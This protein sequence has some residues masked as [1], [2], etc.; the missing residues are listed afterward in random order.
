MEP[1]KLLKKEK[2]HLR[3]LKLMRGAIYT[4]IAPLAVGVHPSAEPIPPGEQYGLAYCPIRR[5]QT[6]GGLYGCA[7]FRVEGIMPQSA[8]GRHVVVHINVGGEGAVYTGTEPTQAISLVSS[9]IDRVQSGVGKSVIEVSQSAEAG[10]PLSYY[11]DAGYNGYFNYTFGR[12][13]FW[14]ADLCAVDDNLLAYYYDYLCVASLSSA[15][16]DKGG[17]TELERLLDESYAALRNS[18]DQARAVLKPLLEGQPEEGLAFTAVGHSHL[19]LAWLW[20][21]RETKRKAQRTFANQLNNAARYPDYVYG[22]SQPW[23]FA[24]IKSQC[25]EQYAA[26]QQMARRGQLEPQGGMWVEA[27]TNVSSGEALIRQIYYGKT[28][29]REEFGQEMKICWLPDVFGYNGNLPQILS[30][31]GLPYFMT[32]KLSWNEHNRFPYRSFLWR[33]IDGS[34]VLVHMP[35]DDSY[36]TAGSPACARHAAD[37]YTE[38][39][40]APEALLVYGIGDGGGGPGEAHIELLKRQKS[41]SGSPK[42]TLGSAVDFFGRLD[43]YRRGLPVY[44]GE[45][46]LEKHQGTYTTQAANKQCNRRCEYALQDLEALCTLA[47]QRGRA[48]PQEELDAWWK[49]VL[50]FQFHDIIPGSS[51]TRVYQESRARYAVILREIEAERAAVLAYLAEGPEGVFNPTGFPREEYIRKADGWYCAAPAP[52]GFAEL[53]KM[54]P[55]AALLCGGDTME[56]DCLRLRF[57]S[58]GSIVSAVSKEDGFEYAEGR[59][60]ALRLYRDKWLFYNAWDIDWKYYQ[61]PSRLLTPCRQETFI[62]GP[63]VVRRQYY[64][65]GRTTI[66]QDVMLYVGRPVMY[67]QTACDYHETLTMLRADFAVGIHAPAVRC[68]IQLGSIERST[69]DS[70]DLEKAQFE[71]CA[72]KYVDV[73]DGGHGVSLMNDCKYGHRVKG[74]RLSLNLLRSPIYPDKTA[75]R[76]HHEFCYAL[77]L[78]PGACGTET[79]A[80]SYALNKPVIP[81]KVSIGSLAQ[82]DTPAVVV[83]TIKCAYAG[84]GV[85]LRLYES[86]GRATVCCLQTIFDGPV[87]ETDLMENEL[88]SVDPENLTFAPFETKT[89]KVKM[90]TG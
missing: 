48:Y 33:G 74:N 77:F 81:A 36:N 41:L 35:P 43:K 90:Q 61:K 52:Y 88:Q 46:Y 20:P 89:V 9:Y 34:E 2:K 5:G 17:R 21:V 72:H 69:G 37:N 53:T 67:F 78:H 8:A 39:A 85:I 42:V 63:R 27:D 59:L 58:D 40:L 73:S 4:P 49:E 71:I 83:E 51:I 56:N 13:I 70:S 82:T 11:I 38:R 80:Y 24:Y 3:R 23:Q 87:I 14:Y 6:W 45:L 75:D 66:T 19:D 84:D 18:A 55:Q 31:S 76:R 68:D 50:F 30:K 29:F 60:N 57:G 15:T 47:W 22:A 65:H 10:Q 54:E 32:T 16:S 1:I 64:R 86:Q 79:L 62:D 28:F 44:S 25:P 12:G 26:L 7:W